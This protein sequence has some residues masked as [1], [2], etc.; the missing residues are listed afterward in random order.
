MTGWIV[1]AALYVLGWMLA[2]TIAVD[3]HQRPLWIELVGS[4]TAS[5]LWPMV[6]VIGFPREIIDWLRK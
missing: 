4:A 5:F 6:V 3:A 1:A 2:M